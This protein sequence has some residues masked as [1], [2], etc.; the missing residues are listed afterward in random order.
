MALKLLFKCH[1]SFY[2]IFNSLILSNSYCFPLTFL[3]LSSY[4]SLT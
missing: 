4:Y 3:L 2:P 1:L